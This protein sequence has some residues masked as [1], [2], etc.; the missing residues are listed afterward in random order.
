MAEHNN[1]DFVMKGASGRLVG[2]RGLEK[3]DS[4]LLDKPVDEL[5]T[6]SVITCASHGTIVEIMWSMDANGIR[7]LPVIDGNDLASPNYSSG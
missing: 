6:G 3:F 1:T 7:H 2:I 4:D 5:V